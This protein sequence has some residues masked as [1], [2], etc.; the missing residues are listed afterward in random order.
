MTQKIFFGDAEIMN[1][2]THKKAIVNRVVFKEYNNLQDSFL[3]NRVLR[4]IKPKD[5]SKYKIVK[6]CFSKAKYLGDTNY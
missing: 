2:V 1:T 6:L 5:R 3:R 4:D